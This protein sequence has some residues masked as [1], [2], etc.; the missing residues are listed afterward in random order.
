MSTEL[1]SHGDSP[2]WDRFIGD[3]SVDREIV[4]DGV[5]ATLNNLTKSIGKM[6][7]KPNPTISRPDL[8]DLALER[9]WAQL[10]SI[11]TVD[12]CLVP[13]INFDTSA[14][15]PYTAFG[16]RD[17][18]EVFSSKWFWLHQVN[19]R[20]TPIWRVSGKR[21]FLKKTEIYDDFKIRTFL[22]SPCELLYWQK[23]FTDTA[24]DLMCK[25]QPGGIRYGVSFQHGG[26]NNMITNHTDPF[27]RIFVEADVSGW[28]RTI[29]LLRHCWNLRKRGLE[30]ALKR[31]PLLSERFDWC[32]EHTVNSTLLLP[33]G[34]IVRKFWG[35]SSGSGSTTGDN[36]I[37]HLIIQ[38]YLEL[39]GEDEYGLE[40]D[41]W[42]QDIYGDDILKSYPRPCD[43]NVIE[44]LFR[45]VY[46][47]NSLMLKESAVRFGDGPLG[48]SFL[49]AKCSSLDNIFMPTYDK[50]RIYAAARYVLKKH[51]YDEEA[52]KI[53][54]LMHLS[55]DDDELFE[56][57]HYLLSRYVLEGSNSDAP[58]LNFLLKD[59]VPSRRTVIASFS[60]VEMEVEA[61]E[62]FIM[63]SPKLNKQQFLAKHK[64]KF[65]KQNLSSAERSK[66]YRDYEMAQGYK[67]TGV[68]SIKKQSKNPRSARGLTMSYATMSECSKL[69]ATALINPWACPS[70]P[71]VPD[72]ITLPSFKFGTYT[73]GI[74]TIGTAGLGYVVMDPYIPYTSGSNLAYTQSSYPVD[75]YSLIAGG[76]Q[77]ANNDSPFE[78]AQF[79]GADP[80]PPA[81]SAR[82]VGAGIKVRYVSSEMQRSGRIICVRQNNNDEFI[83][84][85]TA[86]SQYFL[87]NREAISNPVTRDWH[88]VVWKPAL[89]SDLAFMTAADLTNPSVCIMCLVDGATPGTAF[90]FEAVCWFEVTGTQTPALTRSHSD[91][92]GMSVINSALPA[93]QPT[94]SPAS[95]LQNFLRE[96]STIAKETLSFVG[97]AKGYVEEGAALIGSLL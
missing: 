65:D 45:R 94:G 32:V 8:F 26:F 12:P 39:V 44:I 21:E 71:C 56:I 22:P 19:T 66:R 17:K 84:G 42:H 15:F 79:L 59:G 46:K 83:Q 28:D 9:T 34:D 16:F 14:T 24:D 90:E 63:S 31:S 11:L 47:E 75:Y 55:W 1:A 92:I 82:L 89:P 5:V 2:F 67:S 62:N 60:G 3:K 54:A 50:E 81:N 33:N 73:K 7:A 88:Y 77:G 86:T 80:N 96:V 97:T 41:F 30:R 35:N 58:F 29:W 69:Y 4:Y 72:A 48:S 49:G 70:P 37:M 52:T 27:N 18:R 13:E 61:F 93:H 53:Y 95:N 38:N 91:P 25:H 68:T 43:K 87:L 64:A 6:D 10:S 74:M 78:P 85:A 51:S 36:C 57:F 40:I 76:V 20:S 23:V